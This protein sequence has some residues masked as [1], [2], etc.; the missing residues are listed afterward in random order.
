MNQRKKKRK[1]HVFPIVN[2]FILILLSLSCLLPFIYLLAL[3]FSSSSAAT[4]G[5]VFLWPVG[6]TTAAYEQAMKGTDFL[7]A[8]GISIERVVLGVS[9]NII[10]LVL[11]AYPLSKTK[12]QLPGRSYFAWFYIITMLVGGGLIPTYLVVSKTG[13]VSY[14]HLKPFTAPAR[15]PP[16]MVTY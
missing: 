7:K 12:A 1:M 2:G 14:T 4:A 9:I 10:L 3:S 13:P 11:T 8:L 6:F 5:K 16:A 15:E